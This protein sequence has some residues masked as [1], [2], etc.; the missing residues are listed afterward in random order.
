MCKPTQ[1]QKQEQLYKYEQSIFSYRYI[2]FLQVFLRSLQNTKFVPQYEDEGWWDVMF[3][4][5]VSLTL[6]SSTQSSVVSPIQCLAML[7]VTAMK[8]LT[9]TSLY[10][11]FIIHRCEMSSSISISISSLSFVINHNSKAD[12]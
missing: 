7:A 12:T 2:K 9:S 6:S 8:R 4:L 1:V 10:Q 11:Y 3:D 5:E